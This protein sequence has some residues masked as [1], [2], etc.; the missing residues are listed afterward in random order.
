MAKKA[1]KKGGG[2]KKKT[3]IGMAI[4][5]VAVIVTVIIGA[6]VYIYWE[7]LFPESHKKMTTAVKGMAKS[8]ATGA[9]SR[10]NDLLDKAGK[11]NFSAQGIPLCQE[12][13]T[14]SRTPKGWEFRDLASVLGLPEHPTRKQVLTRCSAYAK[15]IGKM[16]D[17]SGPKNNYEVICEDQDTYFEMDSRMGFGVYPTKTGVRQKMTRSLP[18][19]LPIRKG[20]TQLIISLQVHSIGGGCYVIGSDKVSTFQKGGQVKKGAKG[21]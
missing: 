6:G 3:P 2:K 7:E 18:A 9:K 14:M 1:A 10:F 20:K 19:E 16:Q 21:H 17:L 11:F 4:A 8:A 15:A 5:I 12:A 13:E